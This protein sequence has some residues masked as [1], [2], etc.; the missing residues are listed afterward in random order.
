MEL[1]VQKKNI[2]VGSRLGDEA[3]RYSSQFLWRFEPENIFNIKK[4]SFRFTL[5]YHA[6]RKPLELL[7]GPAWPS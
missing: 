2:P 6:I 3:E 1:L 4:S 5:G 7:E